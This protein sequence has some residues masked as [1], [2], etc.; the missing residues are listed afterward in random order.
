MIYYNLSGFY[1]HFTLNKFILELRDTNPEYFRDGIKI[2]T[3]FGN[4]PFCT[5]DGGR[6]FPFYRQVTKEEIEK[7]RDFYKF[8]NIP[9][10]LIFTNSAIEEEDIYDPFCNLQMKLLEDGNNE[11]VVNSPLL[12]QYLRETYPDF[13]YISSTTKCLNKEKFLKELQNPDYYQVC[14]DYNLNKDMDMLENIPQELRGKCEFLSNAICHSHCPVRKLHYLDTSKTNLTYGKHKYSITTKCQI[15][16]G[17]N[18][19]DTLGKQNNLTWEDIQKYNSMGY[20]YFKFEGRTL[21]SAD[22]FSNYL[23]Y[24]FKPEYIPVIV[25]KSSYV[26]G[27]FFNNPNSQFYLDMVKRTDASLEADNGVYANECVM[28]WPF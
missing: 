21:P 23:Y 16:G 2:G 20:K 22:I 6:N 28:S 4:F 14:L 10:R 15:Q 9:M 25:S 11:V 1:E 5:W 19:P 24:L 7:I 8:Y 3:F 18:D 27:I 26:P 17:I 13:K 12:E